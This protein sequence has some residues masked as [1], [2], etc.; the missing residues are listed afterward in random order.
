MMKK[1]WKQTIG[2]LCAAGL[3][4]M[5]LTGCGK[6]VPANPGIQTQEIR[7]SNEGEEASGNKE[8]GGG[9]EDIGGDRESGGGPEDVGG[10]RESGGD[11]EGIGGGRES[12]RVSADGEPLENGEDRNAADGSVSGSTGGR[13]C[14][15]GADLEGSVVE[16]SETGFTLSPATT[17]TDEGGG[18]EM[19]QAAPGSENEKDNIQITYTD[20][21]VFQIVNLSAS[22]QSEISREDT[23]KDTVK[24]QS[25][26]CVFGSCQDTH[27][28]TADKILILRWQ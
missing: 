23:D 7:Q 18:M 6:G 2:I 22:S 27:N 21:T 14:F 4:A 20:S 24:K 28:W 5:C 9:P 8:S 13:A 19:A 1:M 15:D 3:T 11:S 17:E 25:G 10:S 12:G 16:F 26:V